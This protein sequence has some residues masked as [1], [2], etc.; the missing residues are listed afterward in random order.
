MS[1]DS[2][3]SPKPSQLIKRNFPHQ[4]TRGQEKFFQLMDLFLS[5]H[6]DQKPTFL[7]KGYAGTGKTSVISALVKT[8][9]MLNYRSLMLAPTGRAAKVMMAY[10]GRS[11]YTIHKIIYKPKGDMPSVGMVFD[12]VKNYYKNTIFIV[13]EA[14]MLA[15]DGGMGGNL[16]MDL[17]R[18]VFQHDS[19]RLVLIGDTAQLPPVGSPNSPALQID[20]LIRHYKLDVLEAELTE[21]MRQQ[22]DS[23]ILYNATRLRNEVIKEQPAISFVSNRF[24][25]FFR[26][27]SERLEDG[28]RYAYDKFGRENTIIITRSNRAAVQYN[29]YIRRSLFF[30]EEEIDVGDIL[31]IVRNNYTYMSDSDRVNFLANGDFAEIR[32]IRSFEELYGLRFATVELKLIDYPDEPPFEAKIILDTLYA[33][34]PALDANQSKDLYKFVS[35][36]Y[37]DVENKKERMELIRKDPYLNA[38]QVKF[39]YA[40][41]CHKAQGGQWDAVFVDQGYLSDEQLDKEYIR[42]LYTALTRATKELF[43][44]NFNPRFYINEDTASN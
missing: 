25:D 34:S 5:P 42:W 14:S 26:M 43:M 33:H 29:Q 13:D 20:Y 8:L 31:M 24:K 22:L 18:F 35:E 36:D 21:V 2:Y 38:L 12:L 32:K 39:A 4:A 27:T 10:A 16:L 41:T 30:Y 9:P 15:D 3:P 37:Q 23:G 11:G 44:V 19:N 1:K 7:L 40:L 6:F 28:L 17:I